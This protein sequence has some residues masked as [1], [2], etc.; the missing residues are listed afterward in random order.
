MR[1]RT[2]FESQTHSVAPI[3]SSFNAAPPAQR[4]PVSL[5]E[6]LA[7]QQAWSDN[8]S[9]QCTSNGNAV[10]F[11]GAYAKEEKTRGPRV[12]GKYSGSLYALTVNAGIGGET[13]ATWST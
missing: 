1:C 7:R 10:L 12:I 3:P 11:R 5:W 13:F 2:R 9:L 8:A 6:Y 4:T